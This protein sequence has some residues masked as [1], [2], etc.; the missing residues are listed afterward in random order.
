[1]SNKTRLSF[2]GRI[3]LSDLSRLSVP[4]KCLEL[5]RPPQNDHITEVYGLSLFRKCLLCLFSQKLV[6]TQDLSVPL[7]Q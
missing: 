1:M 2:D 7:P 3:V 5:N 4:G 6:E